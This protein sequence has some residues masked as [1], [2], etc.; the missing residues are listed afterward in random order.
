[1]PRILDNINSPDDLKKVPLE[2][3]SKLAAEIREEI[4]TVV[5]KNGGHLASNLGAVELTLAL[6]YVLDSPKDKIVWDVGHQCYTHKLIT[7]RRKDFQTLRKHKGISGFPKR[8]ESEHDVFGVG[9]ASTS[10]SAALGMACARDYLK[11]D[12]NIAVVVGDGTLTGG[13]SFEG[14][15]NSGALG[16]KMIVILND[17]AMSISKNVGALSKYLTNILTDEKYN[18]IKAEVWELVGK[19]KRRDKIRSMVSRVEEHIKGFLV[20]G[21]IFEKLG[22]RYFGPIDG[23]DV[24]QLVKVLE[25]LKSLNG[26]IL[27]HILTQKGKGYKY[28]EQDAPRFHGIGIFDKITGDSNT[29]PGQLAYTDVFGETLVKLAEEDQKIVA[30]T[31]AMSLGTGLVDFAKKFPDRF[32]DV[33]IAEQHGTTFACGLASL[34]MKPVFAVYSTFLQ[35]AFDQILHDT[36]LQNFPVIFAVDRAGLVGEDGPTHHGG[37]DLS[38]LREIPNLT[39][40]APKDGNELRDMLKLSV[41]LNQGPVVIRYP[42]SAIP[43]KITRQGFEKI[44]P[45]TWEVLKNGKDVLLLAVGSMVYVGLEAAEMCAKEGIEMEVVNARFVKPLDR[46]LLNTLLHNFDKVITLEENALAGGFGS[47]VLEF[48][49]DNGLGKKISI[50]RMGIPDVFVPHGERKT[51]L[52]E[53]G[54]DVDG[55]VKTVKEL[56]KAKKRKLTPETEK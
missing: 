24:V 26:P 49:E 37:F 32:Y 43:D 39:I 12:F 41:G 1:M 35:R 19:F 22:F 13:L 15:N 20:P 53:L 50:K 42:R 54:L 4:I 34:G 38:Y 45:G 31:A 23:H 18:K 8:S 27:L 3:L 17:N 47:A 14:L 16:R 44:T 10:I 7:G 46:E 28:A 48:L 25:H 33:G 36:A 55:I 51:L 56:I 21:I 29:T 40:M 2:D 11:Q 30:I 5:S 6:H 52:R 9:H